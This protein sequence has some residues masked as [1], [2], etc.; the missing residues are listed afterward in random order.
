MSQ[1]L[2]AE[3]EILNQLAPLRDA[4]IWVRGLPNRSNEQGKVIGHGVL[5]LSW[6][7]D[8]TSEPDSMARITQDNV[9][10]WIIDGRVFNLKEGSAALFALRDALYSLTV[11]FRP[12]SCGPL[13]ARSFSFEERAEQY[14][15]FEYRFACES[16]IVGCYEEP[17][18]IADTV[19]ANLREV[20]YD[21]VEIRDRWNVKT[22][23]AD[24]ETP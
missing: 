9:I 5:T 17:G 3:A 22:G 11:G 10:N 2:K 12:S 24:W 18:D 4:E 13:Y 21:P 7:D 6:E 15:R 1:L 16:L 14:W 20:F 8:E 23:F 19:I